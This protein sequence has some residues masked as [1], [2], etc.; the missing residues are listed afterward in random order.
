MLGIYRITDNRYHWWIESWVIL[1]YYIT[2]IFAILV[3][4]LSLGHLSTTWDID[5]FA[6]FW[7]KKRK[8]YV[9]YE[10]TGFGSPAEFRI[11][12]KGP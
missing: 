1:V 11:H 7:A 12:R 10:N 8:V 9:D 4:I 3:S 2:A 6:Q 5:W